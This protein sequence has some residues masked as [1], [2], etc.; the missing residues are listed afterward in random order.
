MNLAEQVPLKTRRSL[1]KGGAVKES[2]FGFLCFVTHFPAHRVTALLG[3]VNVGV[4]GTNAHRETQRVDEDTDQY[5]HKHSIAPKFVN[6][7]SGS[8]I[9]LGLPV[10]CIARARLTYMLPSSTHL[11]AKKTADA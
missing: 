2:N 7:V 9:P 4:I 1:S 5:L 10:S 11:V 8:R 6:F 3:D